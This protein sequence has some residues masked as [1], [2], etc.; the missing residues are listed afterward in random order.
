MWGT[1]PPGAF[2]TF[3]LNVPGSLNAIIMLGPEG[4]SQS[5]RWV[6]G[7]R[8]AAARDAIELASRTR[9]VERIVLAAPEKEY[10]DAFR[11]WNVTCDFDAAGTI[12]H[13][14]RRLS[15]L[16]ERYPADAYLY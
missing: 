10:A 9:G 13:F 6:G 1:A 3:F 11:D 7:G 12:F 4:P 15:E 14:G 2:P 16:L 5:E 8:L